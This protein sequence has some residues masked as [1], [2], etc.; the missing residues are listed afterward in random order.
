[1]DSRSQLKKEV[2]PFF[3]L[4]IRTIQA[5]IY[6][7][8]IA[9][10]MQDTNPQNHQSLL[11]LTQYLAHHGGT[12][13]DISL[14]LCACVAVMVGL[15][16]ISVHVLT[17]LTFSE[18]FSRSIPASCTGGRSMPKSRQFARRHLRMGRFLPWQRQQSTL[19]SEFSSERGWHAYLISLLE[20]SNYILMTTERNMATRRITPDLS[21]FQQTSA[22]P[23]SSRTPL[24]QP[25]RLLQQELRYSAAVMTMR[26]KRMGRSGIMQMNAPSRQSLRI[27]RCRQLRVGVSILV[28][29]SVKIY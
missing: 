20:D 5:I 21:A 14:A 2:C 16:L 8:Q 18:R 17:E 28:Y 25:C 12:G 15:V 9:K 6:V 23:I 7:S 22:R 1:M 27:D 29:S 26:T 3:L 10:S 19:Q 4:P 11:E 13:F 24:I